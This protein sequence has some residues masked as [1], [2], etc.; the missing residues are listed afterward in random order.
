M[1]IILN[2]DESRQATLC[3][4]AFMQKSA[5]GQLAK[6]L[7]SVKAP[8]G[9]TACENAAGQTFGCTARGGDRGEPV[10]HGDQAMVATSWTA[11]A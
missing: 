5:N 11:T 6:G 4:P 1:K 2:D 7:G 3:R 8:V 9:R 10:R